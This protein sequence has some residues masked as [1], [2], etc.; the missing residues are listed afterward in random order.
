MTES[1]PHSQASRF[2]ERL[3]AVIEA[4]PIGAAL[5]LDPGA[6]AVVMNRVAREALDVARDQNVSISA[7][8]H[9]RAARSRHFIDGREVDANEAPLQRALADDAPV[10]PVIVTI[11]RWDGHLIRSRIFAAPL[12][13]DGGAVIGGIGLLLDIQRPSLDHPDGIPDAGSSWRSDFYEI[14]ESLPQIVWRLS[15]DGANRYSN[16][17]WFEYSG[18]NVVESEGRGWAEAVHPDDRARTAAAWAQALANGGRFEDEHRLRGRD[19][20]YRRFLA[21]A[22]PVRDAA[23]KIVSWVGTTIDIEDVRRNEDA[24]QFISDCGVVLSRTL[25][26][27]EAL[28]AIVALLVP[29]FGDCAWVNINERGALRTV[30]MLHRDPNLSGVV[31]GLCDTFMHLDDKDGSLQGLGPFIVPKS[32]DEDIVQLFRPQFRE[33]FAA[34]GLASGCIVPIHAGEHVIGS[35]AIAS[36][37]PRDYSADDIP[38]LEQIGVRAG[39]AIENARL[40]ERQHRIAALLQSA[41]APAA[42]PDIPGVRLHAVYMPASDEAKIGGDWYDAFVLRDG[43]IV[44]TIG[45]VTGHSLGSIAVMG[46]MR[47]S[48]RGIAAVV[49]DPSAMLDAADRTLR[50]DGDDSLVTACI[51]VLDPA[52]GE[53]RY[54]SAGHPPPLCRMPDGHVVELYGPDLPLGLRDAPST[55]SSSIILERGSAL[56]FYT[57]GLT[58]ADRDLIAAESRL[59][60]LIAQARA[61]G[62]LASHLFETMLPNGSPDDVAILTMA[63]FT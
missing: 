17:R 2:L 14:A 46:A 40:Y 7:P 26:V 36:A 47:R 35:I 41:Q 27:R 51:A 9:A 48:L 16:M 12:H 45:D 23:G 20:T 57:D 52:T 5:A 30:A 32:S 42:L 59:A 29:R 44:I 43:R 3:K 4:L 54:A 19:G 22:N 10:G 62:D 31:E 28:D 8:L 1:A 60:E 15:A 61:D 63:L 18:L 49:Q 33:R 39:L 25:D 38:M 21:R 58:E 34:L 13:D 53:L 6:K 56:V 37:T 11:E 24:L 55:P 50:L